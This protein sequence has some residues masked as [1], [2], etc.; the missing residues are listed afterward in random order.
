MARLRRTSALGRWWILAASCALVACGSEDTTD[1]GIDLFD[2]GDETSADSATIDSGVDTTVP[3]DIGFDTTETGA[4]TTDTAVTD[5]GVAPDTADS[6]AVDTADTAVADTADSG[7]TDSIGVDTTGTDVLADVTGDVGGPPT[8]TITLPATNAKLPFSKTSD[9]CQSTIFTTTFTAPAGLKSLQYK[10]I[11]PDSAAATTSMVGT[12]TGAP[13]YGYFFDPAKDPTK[14]GATSG[15]VSEDVALAGLFGGAGGARWW[16]CT[17]PGSTSSG[18]TVTS[19]VASPPAAGAAGV[20]TL[21]NYCYAKTAPP[22]T[23]LGS[24]WQ[25][26]AIIVDSV[27]RTATATVYFW[28]HL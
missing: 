27:G 23:D 10:F 11:T 6:T 25:L 14:P 16:W 4:D 13:A 3:F 9:A 15:S 12:C 2:S 22:D 19:F 1:P 17:T 24:R 20:Q 18:G 26:Q 7:S 5:S 21:S 8:V 28:L